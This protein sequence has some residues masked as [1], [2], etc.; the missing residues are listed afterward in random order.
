M[1]D[2][3][4]TQAAELIAS[5]RQYGLP[6]HMEGSIVR[7][8]IDGV[9]PGGF[10]YA[11]LA[12]NLQDAAG[13]ADDSNQKALYLWAKFVFNYVPCAAH[14]NSSKV[15]TWCDHGGLRGYAKSHEA[16]KA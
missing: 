13:H 4:D 14:G 12:N 6:G 5:F 9:P 7:F 3:F 10:L 1:T 11:V 8:V 15:S 2:H 16:S